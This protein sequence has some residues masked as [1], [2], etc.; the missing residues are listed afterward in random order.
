M[1]DRLGPDGSHDIGHFR[2]VWALTQQIAATEGG[3]Q[4]VLAASAWFHDLVNPPKDSPDRACASTL[5][6]E[7]AV[8]ILQ[9][10]AF[11]EQKIDAVCHAIMA[12]SF[13]ARIA[14]ETLEARVLRDADRLDALGAIG[15]ARSFYVAGRMG[16]ALFHPDDPLAENRPLDDRTF[17]LD[18]FEVKLFRIAEQMNTPTG[19]RI[20]MR[21][22]DL[23]RGFLASMMAEAQGESDVV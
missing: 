15:I 9:A 16:S 14:P 11:P 4:E 17:A 7:A 23:M 13:S 19:Q 21:R 8:P 6:A 18:H 12:H 1:A 2:R 10:E 22:A 20:A 5:S 3:D